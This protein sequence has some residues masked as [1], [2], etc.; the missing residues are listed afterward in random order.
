[1]L[2][3]RFIHA[4]LNFAHVPMDFYDVSDPSTFHQL[5]STL[6]ARTHAHTH[7]NY[8]RILNP[9]AGEKVTRAS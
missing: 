2:T 5:S 3:G 4:S 6:R 8:R 9:A 1:M 7:D